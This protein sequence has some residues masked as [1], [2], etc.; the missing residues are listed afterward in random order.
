MMAERRDNCVK[1]LVLYLSETYPADDFINKWKENYDN[2]FLQKKPVLKRTRSV[3]RCEIKEKLQQSYCEG[4]QHVSLEDSLEE[5]ETVQN[6]VDGIKKLDVWIK[7]NKK[8]IVYFSALQGQAI[9]TLKRFKTGDIGVFLVQQGIS[10][11]V[12]HCNALIRLYKLVDKHPKL[13]NCAV[14]LRLIIQNMK[15]VEE[16]CVELQW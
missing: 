4:Q 11:S 5:L 1:E 16:I 15:T 7:G 14:D 9:N 10:Y 8:N 6:C 13:Q 3:I 2:T 12:S